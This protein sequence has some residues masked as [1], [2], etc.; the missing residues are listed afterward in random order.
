MPDDGL[1]QLAPTGLRMC[2]LKLPRPLPG[3]N[4]PPAADDPDR[5]CLVPDKAAQTGYDRVADALG[6]LQDLPGAIAPATVGG[7]ES[8]PARSWAN[9]NALGHRLTGL[10]Q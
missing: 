7:L 8:R 5:C 6:A 2:I 10:E 9:A 1:S 3:G 4:G